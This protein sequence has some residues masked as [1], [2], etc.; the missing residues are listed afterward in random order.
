MSE[1]ALGGGGAAV[2]E[3]VE[4]RAPGRAV[5]GVGGRTGP[6]RAG[7]HRHGFSLRSRFGSSAATSRPYSDGASAMSRD[8]ETGRGA[9]GLVS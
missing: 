2:G 6:R 8:G 9:T 1:T 4:Q 7:D 5:G 3:F